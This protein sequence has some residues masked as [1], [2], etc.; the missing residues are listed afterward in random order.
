MSRIADMDFV[1]YLGQKRSG[2][3]QSSS[4]YVLNFPSRRLVAVSRQESPVSLAL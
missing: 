2:G 1:V 3:V 4:E